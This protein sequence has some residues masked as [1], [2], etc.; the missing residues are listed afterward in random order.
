MDFRP[1]LSQG[2]RGM[3]N[4]VIL[5]DGYFGQSTGK[6]ANGLVRYSKR[7]Q[8]MGVIDHTKAGEDAGEVLDGKPN[9]IPIV[10]NLKEAI[11]RCQPETLIIGVATFG[12]YIPK[13][14]RPVIREAI[15]RRLNVV[16]GLHEFLNDNPELAKLAEDH[17]VRLVDVRK[18]RPIRESKQFSDLTRK[19]PCLRIPVLGTDGAIGKRTTALLLT[20]ALNA[21]GFPAA[22]VATGQTGLL[23]GSVYVVQLDSIKADFVVGELESE[24]VRVCELESE[25]V[26]AYE[27]TQARVIVVEG[28]GSISHPAYVCGTRAIIMASMPSAILMMHAPARKTRSFR[29]DVVA[30]PM[31]TV[32]EEIEWLQF[33]TRSIGGGKVVGIGINH[34]NMTRDEVEDTM[35]TYEQKYGVPTADPLW[36]GCAKF[37]AAIQRMT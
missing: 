21:A 17:G 36:H 23:Q 33:Y 16:A 29:R 13:E 31:P 20:D 30:W 6:T 24:I 3:E 27:E 32:D 28:Q 4:A 7:Y 5:C 37:V 22:F 14:F 2:T 26:R 10:A 11:E 8:I 18:P 34:E 15:E 9:G 25:I 35:R 19:L 1:L 12:G